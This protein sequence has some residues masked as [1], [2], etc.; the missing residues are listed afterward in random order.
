MKYRLTS[1]LKES[2]EVIINNNFWKIFPEL[3]L[4]D[5]FKTIYSK[6]KATTKKKSSKIMWAIVLLVHPESMYYN[7]PDKEDQLIKT[8]IK[9]DKF[10]WDDY[11]DEIFS[12][13]NL[14]LSQAERSMALWE[15]TM[16][17][18][19]KSI[20]SLYQEVLQKKDVKLIGEMDK[21][22]ANNSKF[23]KEYEQI[24]G[25]LNREDSEE[26]NKKRDVYLG[27]EI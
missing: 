4:M 8:F 24:K 18:R 25:I 26:K 10:N 14:I 15:D 16:R 22:L 17:M 1:I 7:I 13:K 3:K 9:I 20:K 11:R 2:P 6:D 5:E 19:D 12:M 21:M 27:D 23:F